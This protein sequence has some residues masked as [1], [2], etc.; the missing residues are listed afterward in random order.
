MTDQP[1]R[2]LPAARR[3]RLVFRGVLRSV[4]STTVLVVLYYEL[5]LDRPL[6]GDTAVR[7]LIGLLAFTAI[8]AWQIRAIAG[9]PYP[10]VKAVEA[11]ALILPLYLLLFAST[12]YV[13]QRTSAATSSQPLHRL[14]VF[15]RDGLLHGGFGDITPKSEAARVVVIVQMLGDLAL[16]GAG[17]R[18]LL[19]AVQRG[20]QR[21]QDS[22][23]HDAGRAAG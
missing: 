7:V 9:S 10:G 14:A 5:P 19:G 16:L 12:Y 13:M 22:G 8:M 21:R 18:V 15:H 17:A 6:D 11:L 1:F 20:L 4:L 23:D 3:R 2:E